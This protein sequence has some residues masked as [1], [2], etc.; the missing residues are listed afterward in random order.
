MLSALG[1]AAIRRVA[2]GSSSNHSRVCCQL[3]RASSI[4][5]SSQSSQ[6]SSNP[7]VISLKRSYVTKAAT[8]KSKGGR[9]KVA[10]TG[11]GK[12]V[13][14]AAKK[15][16]AKKP[17]AKKPTTKAVLKPRKSSYVTKPKTEEQ[18]ARKVARDQVK[19]KT[20]LKAT[21]LLYKEPKLLPAQAWSIYLSEHTRKGISGSTGS[22]TDRLSSI[23]REAAASY[24]DLTTTEREVRAH[25]GTGFC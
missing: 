25:I 20:L 21:A 22:P 14:K 9:P 2:G 15:P 5:N 19:H 4:N 3:M 23:A 6:S 11:Q 24:K 13:K 1:R 18:L 7:S 17:T 8:S 16:A 12:T 10:K